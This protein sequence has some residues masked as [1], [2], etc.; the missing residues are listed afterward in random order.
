MTSGIWLGGRQGFAFGGNLFDGLPAAI[1]ST[2][3][4]GRGHLT[5]D[6]KP[7][8]LFL[9]YLGRDDKIVR[10]YHVIYGKFLSGKRSATVFWSF[11][12]A[13]M[14]AR[15]LIRDRVTSPTTRRLELRLIDGLRLTDE[16]LDGD[17]IVSVDS[18]RLEGAGWVTATRLPHQEL[19][20]DRD[21][22]R[23][24]VGYLFGP[25]SN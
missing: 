14:G 6:V 21:V 5:P 10:R 12:A 22:M 7:D 23:E 25:D 9:R 18:A 3:S 17:L 24:V 1:R 4:D 11:L 15:Q 8:S 19:K 16:V 2:A 13:R 20:T